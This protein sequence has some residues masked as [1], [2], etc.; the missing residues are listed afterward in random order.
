[1]SELSVEQS[2]EDVL[3]GMDRHIKLLEQK[4][5]VARGARDFFQSGKSLVEGVGDGSGVIGPADP[6][7]PGFA[8]K[9]DPGSR[10]SAGSESMEDGGKT[11]TTGSNAEYKK[12]KEALS[13]A[14]KGKRLPVIE[15]VKIIARANGG[16]VM[17]AEANAVLRE[18]KLTKASAT[19]LSGYLIKKMQL[20]N[21]FVRDEDFGRGVYRWIGY[22]EPVPVPDTGSSGDFTEEAGI[23]FP[24]PS[25]D[26]DEPDS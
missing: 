25:D 21:E 24:L 8:A 26:A 19:T 12:I 5:K 11:G 18:L 14:T 1:M 22:S 13:A 23:E 9:R 3:A 20:S 16:L 10:S 4:L 15:K 7:D 2:S 6:S 17:L